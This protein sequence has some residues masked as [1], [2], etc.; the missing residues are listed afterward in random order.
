MSIAHTLVAGAIASKVGNP[1]LAPTLSLASHFV[2]DSIPHWDFGTNW[3]QRSKTVTGMFAVAD[4]LFGFALAWIFFAP[5]SH[6]DILLLSIVFS[7]LPDWFEAPW[8]I[9]FVKKEHTK[10]TKRASILER[11]FYGVYKTTNKFHAKAT[12][13]MGVV[14]QIAIV[15]FFLLMLQ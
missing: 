6:P 12:F 15:T 9:F 4:T 3:K 1:I 13:P 10:P 7:L 5:T 11:F 14:S 8:Y 2:L